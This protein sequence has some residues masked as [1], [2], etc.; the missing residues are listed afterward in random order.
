MVEDV[1]I[2]D[3]NLDGQHQPHQHGHLPAVVALM[4]QSMTHSSTSVRNLQ[5]AFNNNVFQL[6]N[7]DNVVDLVLDLNL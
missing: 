6:S 4:Q 1:E 7:D 3:S 5:S 2:R